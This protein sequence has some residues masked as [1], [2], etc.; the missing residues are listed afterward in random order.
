MKKEDVLKLVPPKRSKYDLCF[1][2]L[3]LKILCPELRQ[4]DYA[5]HIGIS[6]RTLSNYLSIYREEALQEIAE[7]GERL[8]VK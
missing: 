5:K 3:T 7:K 1:E 8:S 4:S 6:E 2:Y